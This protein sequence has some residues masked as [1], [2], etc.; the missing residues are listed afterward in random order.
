MEPPASGVAPT[1]GS[2]SVWGP[3]RCR[4]SLSVRH[5]QTEYL[6]RRQ[7]AAGEINHPLPSDTESEAGRGAPDPEVREPPHLVHCVSGSENLLVLKNSPSAHTRLGVGKTT[8]HYLRLQALI[9]CGLDTS[10]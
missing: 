1:A 10:S 6:T 2:A 4:A 5:N 8:H 3:A 9:Q 7:V